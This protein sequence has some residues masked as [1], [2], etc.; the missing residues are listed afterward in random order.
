VIAGLVG[1]RAGRMS[2]G[3]DHKRDW[4]R[5]AKNRAKVLPEGVSATHEF[6]FLGLSSLRD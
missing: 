3:L 4:T 2:S 1:S 6:Q 5:L